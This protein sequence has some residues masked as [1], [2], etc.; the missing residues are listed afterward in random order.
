MSDTDS[1][2]GSEIDDYG[3]DT[4]DEDATSSQERLRHRS[5]SRIDRRDNSAYR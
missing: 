1:D 3:Y 4:P 2:Y 5:R